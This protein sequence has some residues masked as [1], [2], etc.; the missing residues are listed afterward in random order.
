MQLMISKDKSIGDSPSFRAWEG[1]QPA[2]EALVV[3]FS[4]LLEQEI[5]DMREGQ[6]N[7]IPPHRLKSLV[8]QAVAY[9]VE[10][11]RYHPKKGR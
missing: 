1:V 4:N 11:S 8:H 3:Q 2:R 5:G 9:Q 7:Y 6:M 10:F